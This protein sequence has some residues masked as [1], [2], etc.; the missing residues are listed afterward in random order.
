MFLTKTKN[1]SGG[2][3]ALIPADMIFPNPNQPRAAFDYDELQSLAASIREN[4]LLQP[5]TVR[6]SDGAYEL[7][8]GERRLRAC[9]I[10]CIGEIPCVVVDADDEKSAV[11]ALIE[12]MQRSDLN[13]YEEALAIQRLQYRYGLTQDEIARKLGRSQSSLSNKIRLLRLPPDMLADIIAAGLSERHARAL[14]SLDNN[15]ERRQLLDIIRAKNLTV[16]DTE[17]LIAKMNE[18]VPEMRKAPVGTFRDLN[19]FVNTLNHAV[20]TMRKAGIDAD[21][22]KSE[23]HEYIEYVI[24]IP[25]GRQKVKVV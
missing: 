20:D 17:K 10:A 15:A 12:N 13:F 2:Q 1:K 16:T 3:I 9:K 22:E 11:F 6:V 19:V 8:S 4:G 23:T 25:K 5:L 7:I 18:A 24:R 21:S 14:L